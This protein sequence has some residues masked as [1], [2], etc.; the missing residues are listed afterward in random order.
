MHITTDPSTPSETLLPPRRSPL[1]PTSKRRN[2]SQANPTSTP[3][4]RLR[5]QP[6]PNADGA[7]L[8]RKP[9]PIC[10]T[11]RNRLA[12]SLALA[13]LRS[14]IRER[15]PPPGLR[16]GAQDSPA[17]HQ[18]PISGVDDTVY[19]VLYAMDPADERRLDGFEGIDHTAESAEPDGEVGVDIRPREQGE[20]DYNKWYLGARVV[21]WLDGGRRAR[22]GGEA[23]K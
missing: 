21:K 18:V 23:W 19:G 9:R 16:T 8:H 22:E 11:R 4:L 2:T 6:L 12:T 15:A 17:A 20:G 3:L 1:L 10:T 13:N 5:L 7:T 14:G